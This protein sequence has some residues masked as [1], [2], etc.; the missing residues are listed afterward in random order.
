VIGRTGGRSLT[1]T[2]GR[3]ELVDLSIGELRRAWSS[4]ERLMGGW[5]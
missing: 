1:V 3:K 4:L 2:R 5:A